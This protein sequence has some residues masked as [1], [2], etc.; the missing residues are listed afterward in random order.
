M[1]AKRPPATS[2]I[3]FGRVKWE[4]ARTAK[5]ALDRRGPSSDSYRKHQW[6]NLYDP[7]VQ[8][9]G[10]D[11]WGDDGDGPESKISLSQIAG[12]SSHHVQANIGTVLLHRGKIS[13]TKSAQFLDLHS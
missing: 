10:D 13:R 7:T 6:R 9:D 2:N 4:D 1:Y 11:G 5:T 12:V 8:D 3:S